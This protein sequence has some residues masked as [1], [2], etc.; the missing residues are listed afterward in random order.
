MM[1]MMM[2]RTRLTFRVMGQD[3]QVDAGC[4]GARAEDGDPL[5]V[6]SKM[7]DVFVE[8]AQ[9]LDL[10]QQAVVPFSRLIAC[11]QET[12]TRAKIGYK[13]TYK[14]LYLL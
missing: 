10:I 11:A 14:T 3:E 9:S 6:A 8:P 12:C 1:M 4:S 7:A 5:V 2:K 13:C